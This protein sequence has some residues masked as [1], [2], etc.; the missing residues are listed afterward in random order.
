MAFQFIEKNKNGN[1]NLRDRKL[2]IILGIIL[3][4]GAFFIFLE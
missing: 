2:P 3:G 4:F 1:L